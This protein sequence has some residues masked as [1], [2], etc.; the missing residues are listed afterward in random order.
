METSRSLTP[1]INEEE[2]LPLVQEKCQ[3]FMAILS[4]HQD[5]TMSVNKLYYFTLLQEAERLEG[6]LDDHGARSNKRWFGFAELVACVRNF[7]MAGFHLYHVLDR[8]SDYLAGESTQLSREFQDSAYKTLERFSAVFN[9]FYQT[10]VEEAASQ[11]VSIFTKPMATGQWDLKVTPQLPYTLTDGEDTLEED[12]RLISIAQSYRKAVRAF[13]ESR[14]DRKV[15]AAS[16]GEI[17]PSRLNETLFAE[18]ETRLHSIQSEYDTYIK[19]GKV[20][21]HDER[22][23]RLRG[24]TAIP[25][26]LFDFLRWL[27]HFYERHE[28]DNRKSQLKERIASIAPDEELLNIILNFGLRFSGKYLGEGVK[29]A[30]RILTSFVKPISYELPIPKPQGFH[31]RPATYVSLVVQEHGTDV[32]MLVN[33]EKYDCRSVLDLLQAGGAVADHSLNTVVF[34]GDR[35]ALDDLKILAENNYCEDR[36]IP[37]ELSYLRILRN[38]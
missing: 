36:D 5:E 25:M 26:H 31:A 18:F 21:K 7:A 20:W 12:E 10:L 27:A 37:Q 23:N 29:V 6:F 15:K 28:S 38:L 8:Y 2:F 1:I 9:R 34:E 14:L 4:V 16:L 11:G 32:F 30:E 33:G 22:A 3:N 19:G 24:L 17:I 13:R 35:R